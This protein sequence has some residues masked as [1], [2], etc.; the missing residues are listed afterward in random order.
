[1][2]PPRILTDEQIGE[3]PELYLDGERALRAAA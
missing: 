3:I 2:A 1:M